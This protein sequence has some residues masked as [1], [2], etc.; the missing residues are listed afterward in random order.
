[1]AESHNTRLIDMPIT[2]AVMSPIPA[3]TAIPTAISVTATPIPASHGTC[4]RTRINGAAGV[5]RANPSSWV[6]M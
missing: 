4:S 3:S 1:V 6:P 5:A 2:D